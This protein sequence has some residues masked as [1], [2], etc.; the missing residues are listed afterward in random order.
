LAE[1]R[2][3]TLGAITAGARAA[4]AIGFDA[5]VPVEVK[6]GSTFGEADRVTKHSKSLHLVQLGTFIFMP[7]GPC[8]KSL[9][10]TTGEAG[11]CTLFGGNGF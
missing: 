11:K 9:E 3:S 4:F 10:G 6:K 2:S 8:G 7:E 1:L 5:I